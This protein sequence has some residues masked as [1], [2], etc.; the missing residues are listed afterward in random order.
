M[1]ES[2][3][4]HS[5]KVF[6]CSSQTLEKCEIEVLALG[7]KFVPACSTSPKEQKIDLLKFS[8]KLMLKE[9][10]HKTNPEEFS[11][12]SDDFLLIRPKSHFVPKDTKNEVLKT[13]VQELEILANEFPLQVDNSNFRDNMT[14]LQRQGFEKFKKRK[15]VVY[16]K[17]DKGA[18][19]VLLD[20]NFYKDSVMKILNTDK[21]EKLPRD[22]E[23]FTL[24]SLKGLISRNKN[25]L[26]KKE[27]RAIL[28]FESKP[29]NLYALPKIH[30]SKVILDSLK[31]CQDIHL[32]VPN[33]IDLQFRLIN[34]GP[35]SVVSGLADLMNTLLGPFVEKVDSRV[36]DVFDFIEKMPKF[37]SQDLPFI[38]LISLD[39]KSMY[40]S[41]EQNLGIPALIY[42]LQKYKSLLPT[43]ITEKFVVESMK[44]ILE[45]NNG[46]FNGDFYK[47]VTGTATGIKPA[48]RY[49][50]LAMGFLEINLFYKLK[51]K[52]GVK[53]AVYFWKNYRRYLD[54]GMIFWDKRLGP[55][56]QIYEMMNSMYPSIKFTMEKSYDKI[57]YFGV[58]IYRTM[59]GFKTVAYSKPTDTGNYLPFFSNHP[60]HTKI[61]IPF[62]LARRIR[63]LT[64][65][66]ELC[67][68]RLYDLSK[69][70]KLSSYPNG[71]VNSAVSNALM[72]KNFESKKKQSEKDVLVY[73]HTYDPAFSK[74]MQKIKEI[75][76]LLYLSKECKSIFGNTEIIE[77]CR[78][79]LS[80]LRHFQRSKFD[81]ESTVVKTDP[82]ITACRIKNC[83]LCEQIIEGNSVFF[84][85]ANFSF[86][87]KTSMNCTVKNVV[88]AL[89]CNGCEKD[90]IG[91]TV[92][93]R[94][95]INTHRSCAKNEDLAVMEVS[96]HIYR[97]GKG[98]K[99]FPLLKV[100]NDC[101]YNRLVEEDILI[102]LLK[103]T[104]NAD[105]R[106]LL[107]LQNG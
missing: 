47:Q 53:I 6:N 45:N 80:L 37:S 84:K 9:S 25:C 43:R 23:R 14:P 79:P 17:A 61:N 67:K 57:V 103:P 34:G 78:E 46:Y 83:A 90:Y 42:Y 32:H 29:A 91:Q 88:Y 20:P 104:L 81:Y 56:D 86:C 58:E 59:T 107:H 72:T 21:Y 51:T 63:S 39:V 50:D 68:N 26:H 89:F 70:L 82:K 18:G 4:V 49:A 40:E 13:V 73:V 101:V 41:L 24:A 19:V 75:T 30:K 12:N 62:N 87:V 69:K 5:V 11:S 15:N 7:T 8:R 71:V 10:F 33:P 52:L 31:N 36:R 100:S 74:L 98:F 106:N 3:V 93:L 55:F 95:R 28:N 92:N 96:R 99:V 44:F 65:D 85:N 60:R 16:F 105:T 54:D 35:K 1:E 76:N 66:D 97:C 2:Q 64:M 77:S 22:V 48:P 38:E 94:N 102:K 27:R